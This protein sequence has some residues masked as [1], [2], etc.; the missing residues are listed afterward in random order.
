MHKATQQSIPSYCRLSVTFTSQC[1]RKQK[2][3]LKNEKNSIE[4]ICRTDVNSCFPLGKYTSSCRN[5]VQY[6]CCFH[7]RGLS[8]MLLSVLLLLTLISC[9]CGENPAI[10]VILSNKG[11]QYG[12][13]AGTDWIQKNLQNFSLPAISG[14][15]DIGLLGSID[16]TLSDITII[17]CD[18]PEPSV[19]FYPDATGLKTSIS[20]LSF[21]L[22]GGWV[23]DYKTLEDR[24]SFNMAVFNLNVVSVME[25]GKDPNDHLSV[26]SVRCDAE[27]GDVDIQFYGG[28]SWV[29]QVFVKHFKGRIISEIKNRICPKVKEGIANLESHLQT[30]NISF[31]IDEALALDLPLTGLPLINASSLNLGLKGEFYNIKTHMEPPFKAQ[32]FTVPEQQGYMLSVGLSEFT[33]NSASYGYYSAGLFQ[34]DINDST[35]LQHLHMH[36]NTSV[37]G[38]L[39]PQLLKMYPG[40]PM[41]LKV[42]AQEFPVFSFQLDAVKLGFQGA[43]KTFA[44]Q[45]NGS[46]TPLFTLN[47]D[48]NFS[49]KIWISDERL[50]GSI[51]MDN[52]TLTLA[53]SEVGTF[54]TEVLENLVKCGLQAVVFPN[55]NK[56]LGE[57]VALPSIKQAHL[58]NSVLKVKEGFITMSSDAAV[59]LTVTGFN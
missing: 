7:Q 34:A 12:K 50:K 36:L 31:D 55:L 21:A 39:I 20:G 14:E 48:S 43:I 35:I 26:S 10:Q 2:L 27:V 19:E 45:T 52:F 30:M 47:V 29:F 8:N 6:M 53:A 59:L 57:G 51:K 9:I 32:P 17:K 41:N 46:Q 56:K 18:L 38:L 13:H 24:G 28:V 25:L 33:L 3:Q 22:S 4:D 37:V 58:V 40:L 23:V 44:I 42:Y 15:V 54:K 49:G 11:L 5:S 1:Y 16:Y